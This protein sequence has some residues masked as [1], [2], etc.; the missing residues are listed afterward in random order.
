MPVAPFEPAEVKIVDRQDDAVIVVFQSAEG[1]EFPM[2]LQQDSVS[3]ARCTV[4]EGSRAQ[5]TH[6]IPR[7]KGRGARSSTEN[8]YPAVWGPF[9]V[10][11]EGSRR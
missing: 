3:G 10:V 2:K 8:A 6:P 11:G 1:G 4:R 7:A 9:A 5:P